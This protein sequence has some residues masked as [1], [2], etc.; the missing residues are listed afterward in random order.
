MERDLSQIM[1]VD[2]KANKDLARIIS[3][4]AHER[5]AASREIDPL[6]WRPVSQFLSDELLNDMQRLLQS[7]NPIENKAGALCCHYAAN[8][9]AKKLLTEYPELQ[10]AI[11]QNVFDWDTLKK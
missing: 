6:F 1:D 8:D 10:Q 11:A 4:Y 7:K 3:D 2:K 9:A 5:W